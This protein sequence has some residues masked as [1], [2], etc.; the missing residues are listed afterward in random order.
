MDSGAFVSISGPGHDNRPSSRDGRS[1]SGTSRTFDR[2][3]RPGGSQPYRTPGSINPRFS[4]Q[5]QKRK[6]L[7][8]GAKEKTVRDI[9][10]ISC[11]FAAAFHFQVSQ[12]WETMLSACTDEKQAEKLKKM[13]GFKGD[14]HPSTSGGPR[15]DETD[16]SKPEA[17]RQEEIS[18]QL[19][20]QYEM[21]RMSTHTHRGMGLGFTS[22]MHTF[23]PSAM[24][25]SVTDDKTR[26]PL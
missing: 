8:Q 16:G 21:A 7:W 23:V 4:E 14:S 18:R 3:Q 17:K 2:Q 12:S 24:Q 22:Q 5:M 9:C 11:F 10:L 25:A 6:L 1:R 13:I 15:D 26:P 19:Q 20:Q